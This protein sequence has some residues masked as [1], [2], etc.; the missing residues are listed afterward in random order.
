MN[1]CMADKK[2]KNNWDTT[3]KIKKSNDCFM[4]ILNYENVNL[5]EDIKELNKIGITN[6]R[7]ILDDETSLEIKNIINTLKSFKVIL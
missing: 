3:Y 6:Y 1:R 5:L 4:H 2:I 7:I